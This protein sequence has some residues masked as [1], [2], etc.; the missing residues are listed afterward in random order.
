MSANKST[1]QLP[2]LCSIYSPEPF[3]IDG[4]QSLTESFKWMK[5]SSHSTEDCL[6]SFRLDDLHRLQSATPND[7]AHPS[8][9]C[10]V[11]HFYNRRSYFR[12]CNFTIIRM[13]ELWTIFLGIN[14]TERIWFNI[15]TVYLAYITC[16]KWIHDPSP[17][18]FNYIARH[19]NMY[20]HCKPI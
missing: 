4:K 1:V 2:L 20:V 19:A 11:P 10:S 12:C 15:K 6:R 9:P 18:N 5:W 3:I 17:L 14:T 16:K 8:C 13:N 7:K